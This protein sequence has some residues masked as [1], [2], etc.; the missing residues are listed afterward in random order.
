MNINERNPARAA[1]TPQVMHLA[2]P[3][4]GE[5]M[6]GED[7][8]P[9]CFWVYGMKSDVA[10]N[11]WKERARRYGDDESALSPDDRAAAGAELLAAITQ[12]WSSNLEDDTGMIP[13]S[14]ERAVSLYLEHDWIAEQVLRFAGNVR[15]YDPKRM[16]PSE[17]GSSNSDGSTQRRKSKASPDSDSVSD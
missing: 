4:T 2:D 11:A 1:G 14:K 15:N 10:R 13:F 17:Y 9:I 3:F 12:G 7:G 16:K 6:T 5:T 8:A